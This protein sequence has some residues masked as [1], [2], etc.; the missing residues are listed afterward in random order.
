MQ[1][2]KG[3]TQKQHEKHENLICHTQ[4]TEHIVY[5]NQE[6]HVGNKEIKLHGIPNFQPDTMRSQY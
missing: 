5:C 3:K 2:F 6:H 4:C 1:Q